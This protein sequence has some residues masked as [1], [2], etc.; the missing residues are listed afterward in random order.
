M[1]V[2]ENI[3]VNGKSFKKQYSDKGVMLERE[4][5]LYSEAID[6]AEFERQYT[7]TDI[8]AEE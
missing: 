5:V 4:G 6:P 8:A 1:I 2:L 7:E 3:T